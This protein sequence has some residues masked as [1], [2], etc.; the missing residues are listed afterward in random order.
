MT[1]EFFRFE[2]RQQLRAP[3]LWLMALMFGLFAFGA[4]SSDA[5]VVGNAV[6]NVDR[7]APTVIVR[8]LGMFTILGLLVIVSF[9]SGA[10]LRD[11][12]L[13]TADLFFSSPMRKRDFLLGRFLAA[14]AACMV[15][16]L[17]VAVG[18]MVGPTMPW[19]DPERL[20]P[21]S[22]VPYAWG[23]AVIVIPNL[24]F[25][26]ALLALL[27]VTTRSVLVVYLGVI[28]FFILNSV[29]GVLTGDLDNVW[30]ATLVDP[31]G[32]TALDRTTRYWSADQINRE[33]PEL[34]GY[35]LANRV[36]WVALS[37]AL[38]AAA[39]ALFKPQRAGTGRGWSLGRFGRRTPQAAPAFARPQVSAP[40][41]VT[42]A[43]GATVAWTQF[44]R[45]WW[46]DT[47]GVFRSVPFLV[48][49]LFAVANFIA[50]ASL[51]DTMFGTRVYPVTSLM[52][53]S[54]QNSY[55]F[56]LIFVVMFYAGELVWKERGARL[57]EVT[58]AMPV[59]NWVPLAAKMSAL[60]AVV[61][62]FQA[63][64]ALAAVGFQLFKGFTA[65]EPAL[66]VQE[67]VLGSVPFVLMGG[68]ALVLQVL[69][70][71]KFIGYGLLIAWLVLQGTLGFLDFDHNLYSYASAPVAPYSD[72]NGYGHFLAGRLW[73]QSYWGA[74]LLALLLVSAAFWV[75]GVAPS[76]RDRLRLARQ[77]LAGGNAWALAASLALFAALGGFIFWNTNVRNE[78]LAGDDAL[79][80]QQRYETLYR[81]YDGLPQPRITAVRTEVDLYPHEQR[82]QVRGQY[83]VTNPHDE[84]ITDLHVQW[85]PDSGLDRLG[86]GEAA[87]TSN[88]E[89][90]GYRI[91]RLGTPM[92]PGDTR[93]MDFAVSY[94]RQGFANDQGWT[95]LV[96]NGTFFNSEEL[97]PR[98][99]YSAGS[100]ISD[101][102]ERRKRGM[103]ELP[104]MAAL[105]DEAARANTYIS[106]DAHWID[107][108]T[109]VCTAPEQIALAPGVREREYERDGRRCFDYAMQ[110]PML[111]FHATLSA[112]W[113]VRK[114]AYKPGT[115]D[116]L[117]IEVY[118]DPAHPFN[119][120]RMIESV[121]KSLAYYEANFSPYQHEQVRILEFPGYGSFAQAFA[122]TI[123]YSESIGFIADLRDEDAIDYV[124]YV[125]AHEIAHQWWAHQVIG[126]DVQGS[127]VL[128]ESLSQYSALM[129]MEKEYGR[130][131]MRRFL[132]YELD[133]YLSGRAG[134]N[135]E[136]LPLYRVENQ[137]YIHYRK[138]SLVFYRLREEIGEDALNR[139]LSKFIADKAYQQ[140]PFTTSAEL[141]EYIRA[142]AGPKH[143]QLITDLFEK[144][145][146]YDNRVQGATAVKRDDGKYEVTLD[147]HAAKLYADGEGRETPAVLDDWVEVGVFARGPSGDEADEEV[148]YLERHHITAESP[149]VTVVVDKPPYEAG[150]DPFNKLIDRVS[151][152]NRRRVTL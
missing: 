95:R 38:V 91:Y 30:L 4:S 152:D 135:I 49:L 86:F 78:Y 37:V 60:A 18:L 50:S 68:L 121:Q 90:L 81:Q 134:E 116:E 45:Q 102:N 141:L 47:V 6:G 79:D 8:F 28:G 62:A 82:V 69:S 87:I 9:I 80:R 56:M 3:L 65:I 109:T 151:A 58:D 93:Q 59:P 19:V 148:L 74:C 112:E 114:G 34:T 64:G 31:L 17:V 137:P 147:L 40:P 110:R 123:P 67:I 23:F 57:G 142:E 92:Q 25:S 85:Y 133:R 131:K 15:I 10:L 124:F 108:S 84:P 83:T 13:G 96:D 48:M 54:L 99:G 75:R 105:E 129:V 103:E 136:E 127:T 106:D 100:Q 149:K 111:N 5:V 7:N 140:A 20:G 138:G 21:F 63:I 130:E 44:V 11:F 70:N 150:F 88:D 29:A 104:R 66:Y 115:P 117:P 51:A 55:S 43:T 16:Y 2:L 52:N 97:L 41:R 61:L 98:F 32:M 143:E 118:Y 119:V 46:F 12:E 145:S 139:A 128:S 125:T 107:F 73:F 101:R 53:T 89:Q 24:L 122:G 77:R 35:L 146:F 36:L 144:I 26:G 71:N 39:F 27:A 120:D 1:F 33:L 113:E 126:A 42:P 22:L 94:A 132:K 72:M 14:V 76:R